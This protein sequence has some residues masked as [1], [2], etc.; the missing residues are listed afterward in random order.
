MGEVVQKI[1]VQPTRLD[2][3]LYAGDG[4]SI[5]LVCT[6]SDGTT[7]ID[8]SGAMEA[9]IR[10]KRLDAD[11]PLVAFASDMTD[12][13]NGIVVMSLTEE[14]TRSLSEHE[15]AIHG[16]FVGDWD[17]QWIPTGSDPRTIAQ[18]KVGCIADVTRSD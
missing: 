17:L 14:Q 8:M 6:Q 2:L 4:V 16:K 5:R 11:P 3:N 10:V 13:V 1:D 7:P 18:G 9:H 15:S 12:A